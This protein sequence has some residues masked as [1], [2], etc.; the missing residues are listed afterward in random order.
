MAL[1][2]EF[3]EIGILQ[4]SFQIGLKRF[5]PANPLF[6]RLQRPNG[7][8]D[9]KLTLMERLRLSGILSAGDLFFLWRQRSFLRQS[10]RSAAALEVYLTRFLKG[11]ASYQD[12]RLKYHSFLDLE[13]QRSDRIRNQRYYLAVPFFGNTSLGFSYNV[14]RL[15]SDVL[16]LDY[17][18]NFWGGFISYEF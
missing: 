11:G 3:P 15:T 10:S 17:T 4:G 6:Q 9:V 8:G 12:G 7:R 5:D 18:R 16:D 14:Y 1:G 13:L 2:V